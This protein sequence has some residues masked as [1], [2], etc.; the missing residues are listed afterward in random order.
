MKPFTPEPGPCLEFMGLSVPVLSTLQ[1]GGSVSESLAG[2]KS[3]V[4][5]HKES[6]LLYQY[7]QYFQHQYR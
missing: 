6:Y 1:A 3:D 2:P 7:S 5:F 4:S